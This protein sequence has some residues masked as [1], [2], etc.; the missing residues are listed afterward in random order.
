MGLDE[1]VAADDAAYVEIAV[2]LARDAAWW[3]EMRQRIE[4]ARAALYGDAAPVRALEKF[5]ER[6]LKR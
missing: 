6:A 1:L 3:G 5:F 4:A 2:R